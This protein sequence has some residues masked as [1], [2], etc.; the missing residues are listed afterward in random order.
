MPAMTRTNTA[1]SET[2]DP[3]RALGSRGERLAL[4]HLERLGFAPVARN[5]RTR[6]GEIDL[7]VFDGTTLAFVEVKTRRAS[8]RAG[9]ALEA[10]AH[11]KQAQVRRIAAAWLA[12]VTD[13]PRS[14]EL[15]FDV[16]GVTVDAHGDLLRLEH[17][18]AAF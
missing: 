3:R 2:G 18:E 13:R 4:Q 14:P 17:L 5:H 15:R 12:E 7:I 10:V 9:S 1:A 11:G 16:I 8:G 6:W